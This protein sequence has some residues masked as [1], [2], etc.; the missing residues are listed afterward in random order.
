MENNGSDKDF[1]CP[2]CGWVGKED[3][4]GFGDDCSFGYDLVCPICYKLIYF[5]QF[6]ICKS[7]REFD[8]TK[9]DQ[10]PDIIGDHLTFILHEDFE[11]GKK[12]IVIY[13]A[14]N[15]IW[16]ETC[17]W[18]YYMRFMEIGKVLKQKYGDRLIDFLPDDKVRYLFGDRLLAIDWVKE[19]RRQ[20]PISGP[21]G[22]D[23]SK[24]F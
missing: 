12:D 2:K 24:Y 11:N 17:G 6:P 21:D 5:Y 22:P 7:N 8:L 23:I 10:L 1:D 13:Q 16:R 19:F 15:E 4:L 20:L 9:P 3:D 18:E 14:D